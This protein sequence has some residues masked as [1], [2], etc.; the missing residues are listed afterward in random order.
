MTQL[1]DTIL[2]TL[3]DAILATDRQ[4][5]ITF[6]NP[7]AERIFGFTS[8]EAV[9]RS[10]DLIVP[11]RL[12]ERH[13]DG[14]QHVMTTGKTQYG[15]GDLLAVPAT[16]KDGHKISVEF[17]ITLVLDANQQI[18]GVAAILRDVTTRFEEMRRLKRQLTENARG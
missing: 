6:W 17:T 4:G 9:G 12:R 14:W 15:A 13:W 11:E 3:A 7:G 1:G 8:E 10:L 5:L 2:N 16:T 18:A